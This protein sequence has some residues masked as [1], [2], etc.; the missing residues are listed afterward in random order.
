MNPHPHELVGFIP[1]SH[2][3]SSLNIVLDSVNKRVKP[4][5]WGW[6]RPARPPGAVHR[7]NTGLQ[8]PTPGLAQNTAP[9]EGLLREMTQLER[10]DA[11]FHVL[12]IKGVFI[13]AGADEPAAGCKQQ[14]TPRSEAPPTSRAS[15]TV[16]FSTGVA[17][18]P[19]FILENST[20][21][22]PAPG[23]GVSPRPLP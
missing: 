15:Q 9:A 23:H 11:V 3:G 5:R 20:D 18:P 6:N 10:P 22:I 2:N 13:T 12:W 8:S 16:S 1:L 4:V 7:L 21:R 17:G 19:S 14:K